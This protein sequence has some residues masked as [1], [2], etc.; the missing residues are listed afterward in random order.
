MYIINISKEEQKHENGIYKIAI[1]IDSKKMIEIE[2]GLN[3]N[4]IIADIRTFRRLQLSKIQF[5]ISTRGI[6]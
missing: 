4:D 1:G 3:A 2:N 5:C 6:L